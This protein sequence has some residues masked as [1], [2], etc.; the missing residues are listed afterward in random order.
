VNRSKEDNYAYRFAV[1]L[2]IAI[3]VNLGL[4]GLPDSIFGVQ[5][6]KVDL[7]SDIRIPAK[8]GVDEKWEADSIQGTDSE[9]VEPPFPETKEDGVV[10]GESG[11]K[12]AAG[13]SEGTTA[14]T[15]DSIKPKTVTYDRF[16]VDS[17]NT[18]IEDFSTGHTGLHRFFAALNNIK[19]L[20]RPVR[21]AFVGDSFI[22]GDILVAD[23]RAKMQA[24]YGGR[25]VGFLPISSVVAQYRPTI[26]QSADGWKTYSIIKDRSK[27]YVISGMH[28]EPSSNNATFKF[29][30]IDF[31]PGL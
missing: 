10:S 16:N 31:R 22:E 7:F 23:F 27:K 17:I 12:D 21:I 9:Q 26:K 20:G 13:N 28:F 18:Q 29:Q 25:G 3:V 11:E 14:Q 15:A 19:E 8:V 24:N 6:K 30:T 5:I 4:Y 1:I 2:L